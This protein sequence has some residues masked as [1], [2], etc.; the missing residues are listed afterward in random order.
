MR[1]DNAPDRTNFLKAFKKY[2]KQSGKYS[3]IVTADIIS[4]GIL[5]CRA[6]SDSVA[7]QIRVQVTRPSRIQ[8]RPTGT[9]IWNVTNGRPDSECD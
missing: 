1:A 4:A 7:A 9:R 8:I 3:P 5:G 6:A 2:S